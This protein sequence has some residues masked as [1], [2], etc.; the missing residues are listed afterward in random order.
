[1][2]KLV[3][4]AFKLG[5]PHKRAAALLRPLSTNFKGAALPELCIANLD[6]V[7]KYLSP[8]GPGPA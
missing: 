6:D 8:P 1:M 4:E 2:S 5:I 3:D 7:E